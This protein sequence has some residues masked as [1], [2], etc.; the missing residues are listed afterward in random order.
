MS[1]QG[2]IGP[3]RF[4]EI[5]D[6][7]LELGDVDDVEIVL[8]H[9][10]GGLT[11]FAGSRIHQNVASDDT[12]LRVRVVRARCVG[13]SATSD[14]TPDGA[15]AAARNAREVAR[16][17]PPDPL[18]AGLASATAVAD[19]GRW[20]EATAETTPERRAGFVADLLAACGPG[21]RAAGAFETLGHEM[22]MATTR[23]QR[24]WAPWSSAAI[25]TVVGTAAGG[26]GY[27]DA[28]AASVS[29]DELDP[30]TIGHRARD[31]AERSPN[32][33]LLAP[34]PMSVILEP[35]AVATVVSFLG[36]IGFAGRALLDGRSA[37]AGREGSQV[38]APSISLWDDGNDPRTIGAPFDAEG[39]PRQRV[40]LIADGVFR[41]GVHDRRT[42]AELRDRGQEA[43]ST[44]GALPAPNPE[45]PIP[46]SL[47]LAPGDATIEEMIAGTERGVLV[48]RFHYTNVADE[49][50]ASITGMTRDGT[51]L[52]ERGEI[53]GPVRNLRFTGS[54]LDML[55]STTMV[56][57][58][59]VLVE[60]EFG[61]GAVHVPALQVES[62]P[63]T[64]VSDH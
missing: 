59:A 60:D 31:K 36:W 3:E 29:G 43:S 32:P 56:G 22:G 63:F 52:I 64:A 28:I 14:C 25:S 54:I 44:G 51:F 39:T 50:T 24:C 12:E 42:A 58:R 11:R 38:A 27:A 19:P 26:S 40:E 7:A 23:G 17:S 34:E 2:L 13:V 10:W 35:T 18:W 9:T 46:R 37:L 6:A 33:G 53:T 48:T 30:S 55:V 49:A 45:G 15:L 4:D 1:T 47:F 8:A 41:G 57:R 61:I 21:T 16:V 62:F 20:F 5:A